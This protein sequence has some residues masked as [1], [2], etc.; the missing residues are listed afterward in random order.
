MRRYRV[1][2]PINPPLPPPPSL[3]PPLP[4]IIPLYFPAPAIFPH[5]ARTRALY[6]CMPLLGNADKG[7]RIFF[8]SFFFLLFF[9][10]FWRGGK[11]AKGEGGEKEE[12][13]GKVVLVSQN[14]ILFFGSF[15]GGI[16]GVV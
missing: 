12:G 9:F 14:R 15:I 8:C 4:W 5:P 7:L 1:L 16:C 3:G 13:R 11:R 6:H 10:F 2:Q